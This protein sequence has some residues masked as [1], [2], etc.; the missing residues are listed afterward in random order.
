MEDAAHKR[1]AGIL[2]GDSRYIGYQESDHQFAGLHLTDL[3]LSHQPDCSNNQYVEQ[4]GSD[5]GYCH[6]YSSLQMIG[7][8]GL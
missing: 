5:K 7:R 1:L 4:Q 2:H 8:T 6:T 3:A